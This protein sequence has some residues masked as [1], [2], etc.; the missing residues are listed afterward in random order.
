MI[1]NPWL[2][3]AFVFNAICRVFLDDFQDVKPA[4]GQGGWGGC[5]W[6]SFNKS[7]DTHHVYKR[8]CLQCTGDAYCFEKLQGTCPAYAGICPSQ[9]ISKYEHTF[10]RL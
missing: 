10:S 5:P 9:E 6:R 2:A 3:C 4:G 7:R 8:I 1:K